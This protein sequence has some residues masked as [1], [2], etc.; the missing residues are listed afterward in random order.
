MSNVKM[1]YHQHSMNRRSALRTMAIGAGVAGA[2]L[3]MPGVLRFA[4]AEAPIKVGLISPLTGAWTVYGKA[5]SAGFE[6]AVDEINAA[7]GV[8]GRKIEIIVGDS[9]TEPRIVVEQANRL[10]RQEGVD[11][12]AGTFSSAERNA[13]GPVVASANKVL[14]YPTFYEG[15]EQKY[16]PG[17]C[18]KNIFM[19]GPEP[20]QQVWPHME[21]MTKQ[22]GKKFFMI[23]S[24]YVWPRVTNEF[25]KEKLKELGGEVVGEVYIPFN[26]PQYESA[27]R[28]IRDAKPNIIFHT[29]TGS[30]TVNFRKQFVAAGMN[31][32]FALWTVDDEEVVTTGLGPDVSAGAF[33]SFD[34]FMS[35]K[36]PNN[37]A[38]LN[39]F[40]A[41][42]GKNA[43]MNTV[44][45]AMYNAAHMAALAIT[46]TGKVTTEGLRD[47]LKD[48]EYD[49]APQGEVKMRGL[50]NQ[51]VLPSYLMK[52][53]QGW[54]G[55]GDMFEEVRHLD[56]V[57]PADAR[58]KSLPL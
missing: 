1:F 26:T 4:G 17:V 52:V 40:R 20:T 43:L 15:Q 8:L 55:V 11:F 9:K 39:R 53:R 44:G 22:F 30:D 28:Q 34:Y 25:T 49:K 10:I 35:I 46:K 16:Y 57:T 2:S 14:L 41:K 31:K 7:G 21:Y 33:V 27:L 32:E 18:N 45:V 56:S 42:F 38:F 6:L 13:A 50:D 51:M 5:H 12:L 24:D 48:L 36:N 29:L 47:G 54:T 3:S 19:F 37:E 23:G 58:C